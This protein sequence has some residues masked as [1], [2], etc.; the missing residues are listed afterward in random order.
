M[1]EDHLRA[2][3]R[4]QRHLRRILDRRQPV[5]D[6]RMPQRIVFPGEWLPALDLRL[7]SAG[8]DLALL[9]SQLPLRTPRG[10]FFRLRFRRFK[11]SSVL[12]C[13]SAHAARR[14]SF[15]FFA[16]RC[17]SKATL[18]CDTTSPAGWRYLTSHSLSVG[19]IGT[20][21]RLAVFAFDARISMLPS[22]NRT[23]SHS[24]R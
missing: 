14:N 24:S 3:P 2:V 6:E 7:L 4:L 16:I 15:A 12:P 9:A 10:Q 21:R 11:S 18:R 13:A 19:R 23:S 1:P 8:R 17:S 22:S 20:S 5:T